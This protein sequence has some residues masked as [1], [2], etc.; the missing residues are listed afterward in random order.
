MKLTIG[1]TNGSDDDQ[2]VSSDFK[3]EQLDLIKDVIAMVNRAAPGDKWYVR[4][5]D[6]KYIIPE[7][8]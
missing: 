4:I 8:K 2:D 3:E 1:R 6:G 5:N 7:I